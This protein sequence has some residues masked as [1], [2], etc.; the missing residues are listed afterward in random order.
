MEMES[1]N[2][3]LSIP[4]S[5]TIVFSIKRQLLI[6]SNKMDLPKF[7]IILLFNRLDT[8]SIKLDLPL[9]FGQILFVL[10]FILSITY[11]QSILYLLYLIKPEMNINLSSSI[12][13]PLVVQL[14]YLSYL[15]ER[16]LTYGLVNASLLLQRTNKSLSTL[17]PYH[18]LTGYFLEYYL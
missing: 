12:S 5:L 11:L 7:L 18:T 9:V 1:I 10:L 17:G 4:F 3:I 16:S 15:K 6:H 2:P 14:I 13:N 8:C